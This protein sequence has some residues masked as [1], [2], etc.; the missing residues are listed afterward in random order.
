MAGK[1]KDTYL[2]YKL[3]PGKD[4]WGAAIIGLPISYVIALYKLYTPTTGLA[5]AFD[6]SNIVLYVF[7]YII[8]FIIGLV[9]KVIIFNGVHSKIYETD[10]N[11]I[12]QNF[13]NLIKNLLLDLERPKENADKLKETSYFLK[14]NNARTGHMLQFEPD[15]KAVNLLHQVEGMISVTQAEPSEWLNPTYNFFLI[16]NYIASIAKSISLNYPVSALKFAS[17]R[18]DQKFIEFKANRKQILKQISELT[19]DGSLIKFL[20]EKRIFVR[21]Y[22][23]SESDIENNK[24]II[25]TLIAGHDLFGCYLY[26]INDD[27]YSS[28]FKRTSEYTAFKSFI[29]SIKYSLE[30]EDKVDLAMAQS[31][32]EMNAIYRKENEL[33][34]K[35]VPYANLILFET[36]LIK[37]ASSLFS[38]YNEKRYLFDEYFVEKNFI[39]NDQYCHLFPEKYTVSE[40]EKN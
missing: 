27:F 31:N 20:K 14:V 35:G 6:A 9:I 21:F 4:I 25:E 12:G 8:G 28:E 2:I 22:I 24:S 36:F 7:S 17:N 5:I 15:N 16:N 11:G 38:H 13:F 34:A 18:V 1:E 10:F 3:N 40:N 32:E 19:P 30:E 33:I 26:F 23:L 37:L 29:Q 39:K